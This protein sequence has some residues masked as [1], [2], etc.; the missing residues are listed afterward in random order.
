MPDAPKLTLDDLII[1][2]RD[3]ERYLKE[4]P[5]DD[6]VAFHLPLPVLVQYVSAANEALLLVQRTETRKR[7]GRRSGGRPPG[8]M[9]EQ[10]ARQIA[11]GVRE[12]DAVRMIAAA[13]RRSEASVARAYA[14]GR[15]KKPARR[16][17]GLQKT[18]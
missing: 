9:G 14:R 1:W 12:Q 6:R 10:V 17:T 5:R 4:G 2:G 11:S 8:G 15:A 18:S 16:S 3:Y 13:T 7:R